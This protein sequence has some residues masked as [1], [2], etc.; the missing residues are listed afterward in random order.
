MGFQYKYLSLLL[1]MACLT[2][3]KTPSA[4][5][6]TFNVHEIK[7]QA[8]GAVCEECHGSK[9]EAF[10][11]ES[12]LGTIPKWDEYKGDGTVMCLACHDIETAAHPMTEASIDF[13]VPPDLPLTEEKTLTCMTCHYLHGSLKSDRPWASVSFMDRM[14]GSDRMRKTYVLRRNNSNGELC[15]VCH[16]TKGEK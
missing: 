9:P 10:K 12:S 5:E 1:F 4:L 15:L 8:V 13:A 11:A 16:E 2:V 6:A 14:S 3:P 7:G